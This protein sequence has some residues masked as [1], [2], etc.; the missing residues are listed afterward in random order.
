MVWIPALAG[1]QNQWM[2]YGAATVVTISC[3]DE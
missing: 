2:V 1:I 3:T